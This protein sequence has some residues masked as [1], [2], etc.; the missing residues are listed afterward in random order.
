MVRST[1]FPASRST[2][3][4]IASVPIFWACCACDR[5]QDLVV[6][7]QEVGQLAADIGAKDDDLAHA[8]RADHGRD[9]AG[10]AALVCRPDDVQVGMFAEDGAGGASASGGCQASCCAT[11]ST[12]GNFDTSSLNPAPAGQTTRH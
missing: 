8:S 12:P 11:N 7:Q 6:G 10:G 1:G 2:A 9:G 3:A 4:C 5:L